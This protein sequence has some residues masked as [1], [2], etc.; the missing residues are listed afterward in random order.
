MV[1]AM[2]SNSSS[3]QFGQFSTKRPAQPH[4]TNNFLEAF[5]ESSVQR[6]FD[7]SSPTSFAEAIKAS[8]LNQRVATERSG[9]LR[10]GQPLSV[11]EAVFAQESLKREEQVRAQER[12]LARLHEEEIQQRL[13]VKQEEVKRQIEELREIILKIAKS[14]QHVGREIEKAAFETP[15]SPGTYHLS[16]FEK[17]K[18]TLELIK[19]RLDD[20]ASW[21]HAMNDRSK[22]RTP[23]FWAQVQKSGTKY[24][25]SSERNM[26]MAPG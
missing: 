15:V 18:S 10:P 26:Q 2:I 22:K 13:K 1:N 12:Q 25:L 14:T 17:L 7:G 8:A 3:N 23:Y 9:E 21:L 6:H 11:S 16:F 4:R 20:S 5:K 24:M 19:K